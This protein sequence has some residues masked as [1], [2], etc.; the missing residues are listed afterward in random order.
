MASDSKLQK[1]GIKNFKNCRFFNVLT[2]VLKIAAEFGINF[3]CYLMPDG[4]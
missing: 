2:K 3:N 4:G 1:Y